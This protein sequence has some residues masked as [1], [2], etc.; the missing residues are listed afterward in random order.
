MSF[1]RGV[2]ASKETEIRA[3]VIKGER[4]IRAEQWL[5]KGSRAVIIRAE[6]LQRVSKGKFSWGYLRESRA[7]F[8]NI[9]I[10]GVFT[11]K[12]YSKL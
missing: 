10:L 5:S 12:P 4:Q 7:I 3:M 11:E 6:V 1:E 8:I 2:P 9:Y